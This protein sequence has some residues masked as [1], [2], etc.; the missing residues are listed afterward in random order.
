MRR[1]NN[2]AHSKTIQKK[3]QQQYYLRVPCFFPSPI[4]P[5]PI[6][7]FPP[8]RLFTTVLLPVSSSPHAACIPSPP[9]TTTPLCP[10][11]TRPLYA[12]DQPTPTPPAPRHPFITKKKPPKNSL[13]KIRKKDNQ[14]HTP[15]PSPSRQ[16]G[17]ENHTLSLKR[18]HVKHLFELTLRST[19]PTTPT[20]HLPRPN[21]TKKYIKN[22]KK[23]EQKTQKKY[24]KHP[25]FHL[26]SHSIL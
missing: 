20:V 19:F 3:S 10:S 1:R 22:Y 13:K 2:G 8:T 24:I 15:N 26:Y 16:Q 14:T 4:A 7:P 5:H 23:N 25:L 11:F 9:N 17:S 21:Q 18:T 6:P 12:W